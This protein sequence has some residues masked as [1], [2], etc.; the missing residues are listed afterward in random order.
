MT[1]GSRRFAWVR[2]DAQPGPF[3]K[4]RNVRRDDAAERH[5]LNAKVWNRPYVVAVLWAL[6]PCGVAAQGPRCFELAFPDSTPSSA[7]NG[8]TLVLSDMGLGEFDHLMRGGRRAFFGLPE[9]HDPPP[10]TYRV[11]GW[12][13]LPPDSVRIAPLLFLVALVWK[14]RIVDDQLRGAVTSVTDEAGT[15]L[16]VHEFRG[17]EVPCLV[18]AGDRKS[19]N[20]NAAGAGDPTSRTEL[21]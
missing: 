7:L 4:S 10:L 14:A 16:R 8:E 12:H 5:G 15:P 17:T 3:R 18:D 19:P 1:R 6:L 2:S 11:D 20:E 13:E 9:Y 21:R